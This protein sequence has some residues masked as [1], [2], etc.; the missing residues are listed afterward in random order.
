MK[1]QKHL[2]NVAKLAILRQIL[3]QAELVYKT[4]KSSTMTVAQKTMRQLA[5]DTQRGV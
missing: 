1:P 4:R 3:S 2:L 5:I